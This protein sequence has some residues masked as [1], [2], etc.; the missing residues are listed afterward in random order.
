[1]FESLQ[2]GL[3]GLT[4]GVSLSVHSRR[5][6]RDH[7]ADR[8]RP[9]LSGREKGSG[10]AA[11]GAHRV[12]LPAGQHSPVRPDGTGRPAEDSL[13][14]GD[15]QRSL[16]AA[17]F[18]R[19][20]RHDRLRLPAGKPENAAVRRGRAIRHFLHPAAGPGP[21]LSGAGGG[22]HR[23]HRRLRRAHGDL[24]RL[25]VRA[26][27]ARA[28]FGRGVF[29]HGAGAHHPA[30]DHAGADHARGARDQDGADQAQRLRHRPSCCSPSS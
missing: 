23:R 15:R 27:A 24:R 10:A 3:Y 28:D 22:Q 11:A 30:A 13:R 25:A 26:A 16:P 29:L 7:A 4:S 8:R 12:R 17:D 18:R 2:T 14:H 5:A 1:M 20:R 6:Q 19:H 21:G 9:A